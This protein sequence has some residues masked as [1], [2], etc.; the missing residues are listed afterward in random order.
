[1]GAAT[2]GFFVAEMATLESLDP[3]VPA[4]LCGLA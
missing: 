2:R 1:M 3:L 4:P